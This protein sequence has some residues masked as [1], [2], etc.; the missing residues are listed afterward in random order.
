MLSIYILHVNV[1]INFLK[2]VKI[3]KMCRY[4]MSSLSYIYILCLYVIYYAI[5]TFYVSYT[6]LFLIFM[7]HIQCHLLY[8]CILTDLFTNV[9]GDTFS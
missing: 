5:S 9:A 7:C 1:K 2:L 8:A 4:Y 6:M 3:S